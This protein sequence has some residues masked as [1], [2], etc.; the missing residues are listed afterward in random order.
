MTRQR[1]K[2]ALPILIAI[3][4]HAHVDTRVDTFIELEYLRENSNT[5]VELL[6]SL[7]ELFSKFKRR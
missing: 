7:K 6:N 3:N 2:E 5:Q 4:A 1:N